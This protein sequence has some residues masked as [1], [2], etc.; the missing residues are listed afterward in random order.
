MGSEED[1]LIGDL[2]PPNSTVIA[3][4]S[5]DSGAP[6]GRLILPQVQFIRD[7]LDHGI[8]CLVTK[9]EGLKDAI[10]ELKEVALVVTDSQN[11]KN[12]DKLVPDGIP[13]TSFSMLFARQKGNMN[14]L[15]E[16]VEKVENLSENARVLIAEGC[17]HNT[18]H[19]DIGRVKIPKLLKEHTGWISN[20]IS[21]EGMTFLKI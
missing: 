2:I 11:F 19:E 7:C 15:L 13:L 10:L 12:I 4:V 17:T 14:I 6:K 21:M 9:E 1:S 3:V 20:L 16:G 5:I 18:T 8:K